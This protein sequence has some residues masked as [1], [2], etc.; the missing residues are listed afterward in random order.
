MTNNFSDEFEKWYCLTKDKNTT[1]VFENA[2]QYEYVIRELNTEK[3][4]QKNDNSDIYNKQ[5][6]NIR[7]KDLLDEYPKYDDFLTALKEKNLR[8][9]FRHYLNDKK[10][11]YY[12]FSENKDEDRR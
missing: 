7:F 11:V 1:D 12:E 5:S 10:L 3:P 8:L 6:F 4:S 2:W 9:F